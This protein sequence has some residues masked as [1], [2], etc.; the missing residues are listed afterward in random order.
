MKHDNN[1]FLTKHNLKKQKV[2]KY[3]VSQ[4]FQNI[5]QLHCF[6]TKHICTSPVLIGAAKNY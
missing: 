1:G 6:N 3:Y 4:S 2:S 5:E